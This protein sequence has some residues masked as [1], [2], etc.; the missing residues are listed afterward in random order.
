MQQPPTGCPNMSDIHVGDTIEVISQRQTTAGPP[1]G[2][3]CKVLVVDTPGL[4]AQT[5]KI[6]WG[7]DGWWMFPEDLRRV[8]PQEIDVAQ[9]RAFMD[10][11]RNESLA[12]RA[13]GLLESMGWRR[14]VTPNTYLPKPV[15]VWVREWDNQHVLVHRGRADVSGDDVALDS[16][17]MRAF[18]DLADAPVE[19]VPPTESK[20]PVRILAWN[21]AGPAISCLSWHGDIDWAI[22]WSSPIAL[23][24][25][26]AVPDDVGLWV[27][28]GIATVTSG[29]T[30]EPDTISLA[31]E[32]RRPTQPEALALMDGSDVFA[33]LP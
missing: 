20:V 31:G 22:R 13:V 32:W 11:R 1:I 25:G 7:D 3:R 2:L 4:Y 24:D 29:S 8:E 5:I 21:H 28:E 27:W 15:S 30:S 16:D 17:I 33:V 23:L 9:V 18:A 14:V 26:A 19:D 10:S 6:D 12:G